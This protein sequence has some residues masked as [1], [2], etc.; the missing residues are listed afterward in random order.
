MNVLGKRVLITG[1]SSGIGLATATELARK[2]AGV[3]II[4]RRAKLVEEGIEL[5]RA[6][7]GEADGTG[8]D[9]ATAEGRDQALASAR[10]SMG[11]VDIL[12]NC[13]GGVRAGSLEDTSESDIA[14]MVEVNLLA[15]ILLARAA[16]PDLRV[17][18]DSM[19]V[20][21]SSGIALVGV[22][23]YTTY[24]AVK[25]GISHFGEALR[26]ELKGEGVHVLTVYPG[27]TDTP[28]MTSS[29]A[30]PDLGF[31]R[32]PAYAVAQAIVEG[33]EA[34]SLQVIRGGEVREAMIAQNRADPLALDDRFT[35]LKPKLAEAVMDHSAL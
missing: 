31:I 23:F 21:V 34:N 12:I 35:L 28:M 15:P 1:G 17:S 25:A 5:L 10:A 22:P 26:R 7:G 27:A 11:G 20:N 30:G 9:I 33:I 18:G 8:V 29:R 2:G 16:M 14:K 24:A 19:I 32:E 3:F 13:A 6:V 4:G